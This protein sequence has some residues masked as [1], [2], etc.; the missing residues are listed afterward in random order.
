[1]FNSRIIMSYFVSLCFLSSCAIEFSVQ[2]EDSSEIEIQTTLPQYNLIKGSFVV[3]GKQPDGDSVR[4]LPD[5]SDLIKRLDHGDHAAGL[6]DF[7]VG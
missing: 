4:F 3:M 2:S 6:V 5:D 1:M 7:L